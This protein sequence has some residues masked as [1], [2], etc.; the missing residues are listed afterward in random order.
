[1]NALPS[2]RTS[3][4]AHP[5][6]PQG[7]QGLSTAWLLL[8]LAVSSLPILYGIYRYAVNIPL[9][10]EWGNIWLL[11][12]SFK[13]DLKLGDLLKPQNEYRQLV[14]NLLFILLG[15]T[16]KLNLKW[17]MALTLAMVAHTGWM[18]VGFLRK[19]GSIPPLAV[20]GIS[21]F[22]FTLLFMPAQYEN[23]VLGMQ[24]VYFFPVYCLTLCIRLA[25]S[26][27]R[28]TYRAA[29]VFALSLV[30]TLSSANGFL[31]LLSLLCLA[32]EVGATGEPYRKATWFG[33][34]TAMAAVC[35]GSYLYN[36]EHP[37]HLTSLWQKNQPVGS[38]TH[39]A[40]RLAGNGYG[41]C[42]ALTL[43]DILGSMTLLCLT[44]CFGLA[45][46]SWSDRN[47]SRLVLPWLLLALYGLGNVL[48][49]TFG[50]ANMGLPQACAPR[51]AGFTLFLPLAVTVLPVVHYHI[52]PG[53][54]M[55]KM[56]WAL[57]IW[58]V[59]ATVLKWGGFRYDF[60]KLK[61]FTSKI[62]LGKAG[63]ILS[64]HI[65][66]SEQET[67]LFLP[68]N[69]ENLGKMMPTF[70]N[71]TSWLDSNQMIHPRLFA[72]PYLSASNLAGPPA[73]GVFSGVAAIG[74]SVS[75]KGRFTYGEPMPFREAV[76]I[77][78]RDGS[79][80]RRFVGIDN[81]GSPEWNAV[82]PKS[83]LNEADNLLE[84]WLLDGDTGK[85]RSIPGS[86]ATPY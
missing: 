46:K 29:L 30:S 85:F 14:P 77:T 20:A 13:G 18:W 69:S 6:T 84:A 65:P 17:E 50:R 76:V 21:F 32:W 70:V 51:Y 27:M 81:S 11:K 22:V 47:F 43:T 52:R 42:P 54:G 45:F 12:R 58:M 60:E 56:V 61:A 24:F 73:T 66:F 80:R 19:A 59:A 26:D 78:S 8:I 53:K 4:S 7:R 75:A 33:V 38:V 62:A 36:Y 9:Y 63:L 28:L 44:F 37:G 40:F 82:F 2:D 79:G 83:R 49:I 74:D 34:L 86:H 39:F 25:T 5:G 15:Y 55:R 31:C 71:L 3:T 41:T 68:R 23:W 10:D 57:S 64:R 1:M 35:I 48:L 72:E 16:A 67:S